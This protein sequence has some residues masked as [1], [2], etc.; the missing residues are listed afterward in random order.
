[1]THE[2]ILTSVS[3][4]LEQDSQGFCVVGAD[5]GI[6]PALVKRLKS[7]SN[8]RHLFSPDSEEAKHHP[9]VYSHLIVPTPDT[10]WH[11]LS[12][13]ADTGWD[14]RHETNHLAHHIVLREEEEIEEGP[15]WLLGLYG[16]HL[17]EWLTPPVRFDLG[18][19][20]PTLTAP[21]PLTRRQRIAR[22]R[23]WLDHR[24]TALM[25]PASEEPESLQA[26]A[27]ENE[28]QMVIA[29][30]PTTPCSGWQE[31]LGD[32][33][34]GGIL[35]ETIRTAQ[36]AVIVYR[37]GM[38]ILPL[39]IEALSILPREYAWK[40]TF[41]TFF[42][43]LPEHV[44]CQWK[45]VVAGTPEADTLARQEDVLVIDLTIPM[46]DVPSGVYVEYARHG[47]ENMLPENELDDSVFV[48]QEPDTK[49]FY[50]SDE[51]EDSKKTQNSTGDE[52]TVIHSGSSS[53][54]TPPV[55]PPEENN[56]HSAFSADAPPVLPPDAITI[57]TR[58]SQKSGEHLRSLLNM[59]SRRQF[60]ALYGITLF[61]VLFLI[62]LVLD[63]F[64]DLGIARWFQGTSP[65]TKHTALQQEN[66][67]SETKTGINAQKIPGKTGEGVD[68][69]L[70]DDAIRKRQESLKKKQEVQA[71]AFAEQKA[72]LF[73][74]A[75]QARV[76]FEDKCRKS[77]ADLTDFLLDFSLPEFSALN[78]PNIKDANIIPPEKPQLFEDFAPLHRFGLGLDIGFIPLL[79]IPNVR[80][81][82][83]KRRLNQR[84]DN[85]VDSKNDEEMESSKLDGEMAES[86]IVTGE[87]SLLDDP[88]GL[89][90]PDEGR[91]EWDVC[92]IDEE[93]GNKTPIFRL[94]LTQ[95]GMQFEW[96]R[97]GMQPQH[98]FHTLWASL[99]FL[100]VS[101]DGEKDISRFKSIALFEPKSVE[102]IIFSKQFADP[103]KNQVTVE[104]PFAQ[105]PWK[106]LWESPQPPF[107]IR[108]ETNIFPDAPV[109][110]E[111]IEIPD[112]LPPSRFFANFH[113]GISSRKNVGSGQDSYSPI[114]IPFEG[115][116]EP[117]K[118]VWT[119]RYEDQI[120]LLKQ[121]RED[122]ELR[123]TDI[124]TK[125]EAI[126]KQIF[127]EGSKATPEMR[128]ERNELAQSLRTLKSR[129]DEIDNILE[130]LPTAHQKILENNDLR[131]EYAVYLERIQADTETKD[132]SADSDNSIRRLK[133]EESILLLKSTG[134]E[135]LQKKETGPSNDMS[136]EPANVKSS[137]PDGDNVSEDS[138]DGETAEKSTDTKQ[139]D[140]E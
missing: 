11:V 58:S 81:E 54:D 75:Q 135:G 27:R 78:V 53:I 40:A 92:A 98:F 47:I 105:E 26:M 130:N 50:F 76:D 124:K 7:I 45:G 107:S 121:E 51:N 113:T 46:G 74:Q 4:G 140:E 77:A 80:I 6:P 31:M 97:D 127:N 134:A 87:S 2:L 32:A 14:Y 33:G 136:K 68:G 38:N 91:F 9:I 43:G 37:P 17:T 79:D 1:M 62:L 41:T 5:R 110:I 83:E 18:R 19:P 22:E 34:W 73:K 82:T 101:V 94:N 15:V 119:D 89:L 55:L 123:H 115:V 116:A 29:G 70:S 24:K 8:Y 56:L 65:P 3:Q 67:V 16:F 117:E 139:L 131:F 106:T 39:F 85:V 122:S 71:K 69:K 20:I 96:L 108:I 64:I 120:K 61:L 52:S 25:I 28:E 102:P 21:P 128:K 49:P 63:Q 93:T 126:R 13:I 129:I 35:A 30:P 111:E 99:G 133:N 60:Y 66:N 86:G 125:D 100:R 42:T 59:K 44:P 48:S 88:E 132:K 103:E 72:K 84:I 36:P 57:R 138:A 12:R 114:V 95:S 10:S 109:G 23:F 112:D 104:M 137:E 118:I 90:V